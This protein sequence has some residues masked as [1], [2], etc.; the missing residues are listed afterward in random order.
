MEARNTEKADKGD[1]N[2]TLD[3]DIAAIF[4]NSNSISGK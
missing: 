1:L 4:K 3:P 2:C